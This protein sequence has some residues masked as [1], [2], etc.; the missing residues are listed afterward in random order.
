MPLS[1]LLA[2][3][4]GTPLRYELREYEPAADPAAT[5]IVGAARFTV[6]TPRLIRIE[7]D[8]SGAF[9][10]RA[11]L[12]FVNRRLDVPDFTWDAARGVLATSALTLTYAGGAFTPDSLRVDPRP[13]SPFAHAD[14][15]GGWRFGMTS[16]A[17]AGNLRGTY[18]TLDRTDNATLDCNARDGAYGRD[19][20]EWG[21]VSRSGWALV[22]E[23]GVPCLDAQHDW[24]ADGA[25]K[26]LR[27]RDEHDLYLFAHGH[28]YT[29]A[30]A[31]LT[32]AGGKIP[33]MPRR[34]A[35]VWFT[36]WYDYAGMY[37]GART[38][39]WL[40]PS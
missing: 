32:A 21:V 34:N 1:L 25:G 5:V 4:L 22:N 24:W 11:T 3:A 8:A 13:G 29:G 31:D 16:A 2:A 26:M 15:F 7:Y 36:R 38:P 35:G 28:D 30:L 12:A 27:N 20:C 9:E 14:A 23:T 10:D 6:L 18:R 19:H 37:A 17:D 39:H 33:M 40:K